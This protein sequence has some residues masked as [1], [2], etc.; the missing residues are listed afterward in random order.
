MKENPFTARAK[1]SKLKPFGASSAAKAKANGKPT[2]PFTLIAKSG[3]DP[4][5]KEVAVL[6]EESVEVMRRLEEARKAENEAFKKFDKVDV[7][8]KLKSF[9]YEALRD[10]W[11]HAMR[12]VEALNNRLMGIVNRRQKLEGYI[13]GRVKPP[14]PTRKR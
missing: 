4:R 2:S 1:K 14:K 8:S 12:L 9:K 3:G 10:D 5:K 11:Q 13:S 6:R 7:T